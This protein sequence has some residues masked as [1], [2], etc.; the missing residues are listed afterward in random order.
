MQCRCTYNIRIHLVGQT[1]TNSIVRVDTMHMQP[2]LTTYHINLI[3]LQYH[4]SIKPQ[5]TNPEQ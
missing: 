1:S 2:D 3:D 4:S 5:S